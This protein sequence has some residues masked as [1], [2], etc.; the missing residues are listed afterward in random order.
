[1]KCKKNKLWLENISNLFCT[2]NLIPLNGMSLAEQMNSLSR[3]VIVIF[4]VLYLFKF[5]CS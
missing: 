3:L 1:M 5:K 2:C 4:F